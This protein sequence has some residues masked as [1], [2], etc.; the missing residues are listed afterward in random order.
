VR[1]GGGVGPS[2]L[3]AMSSL[4]REKKRNKAGGKKI[5]K[6]YY[7]TQ[8]MKDNAAPSAA[9]AFLFIASTKRA[10]CFREMRSQLRR[11][12]PQSS[13]VGGYLSGPAVAAA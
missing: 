6:I 13:G 7:A 2:A 8:H 9:T 3:F 1:Q 5:N 10:R 12:R 4:C 11:S